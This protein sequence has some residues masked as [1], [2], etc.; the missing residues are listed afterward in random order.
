MPNDSMG[1]D[2][3]KHHTKEGAFTMHRAQP[4]IRTKLVGNGAA[5]K[6]SLVQGSQPSEFPA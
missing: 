5:P 4:G 6:N 3:C 2:C 1:F